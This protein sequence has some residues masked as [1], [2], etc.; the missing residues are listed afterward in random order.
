MSTLTLLVGRNRILARLQPYEFDRLAPY[1][2]PVVMGAG[3]I[4]Y[5]SG[6]KLTYFY[7]PVTAILSIQHELED[8]RVSELAN[9]GHEG[10]LGVSLFMGGHTTPNRAVVHSAGE[11]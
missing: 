1:L 5:E 4:L 10:L 7:F 9:V 8:G 6:G 11:A 3:D 2:E